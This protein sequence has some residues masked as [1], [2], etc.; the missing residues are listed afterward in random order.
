MISFKFDLSK[1]VKGI[2]KSESTLQNNK[3]N[4]LR[5][6][7]ESLKA[8]TSRRFSQSKEPDIS[9]SG[10]TWVKGVKSSGKTLLDR[11][12]LK[13]SIN[14]N[15]KGNTVN[16]GSNLIYAR[17]HQLGGVIKAKNRGLLRFKING[18]YVSKKKVTIPAR[19][20]LGFSKF[21]EREFE[22]LA[23]KLFKISFK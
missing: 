19:P 5:N 21:D 3:T 18:R 23:V 4:L 14:Y 12:N 7:G 15:V 6:I 20:Y 17:I 10:R 22:R 2:S 11:G 9:H 1:L 16:I 13:N 8:S